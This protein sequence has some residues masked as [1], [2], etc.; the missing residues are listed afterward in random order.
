MPLPLVRTLT[1]S[2]CRRHGRSPRLETLLAR[3]S[4]RRGMSVYRS[5]ASPAPCDAGTFYCAPTQFFLQFASQLKEIRSPQSDSCGEDQDPGAYRPQLAAAGAAFLDRKAVGEVEP[6]CWGPGPPSSFF[7]FLRLPPLS[8]GE[9][10][11]SAD[12]GFLS[13]PVNNCRRLLFSFP[14]PDPA[15]VYYQQ[16]CGPSRFRTRAFGDP[17]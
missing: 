15:S 10:P 13:R 3:R 9:L 14:P 1:T 17:A 11:Q 7:I 5:A 4:R 16:C 6:G 8:S 12:R 2:K